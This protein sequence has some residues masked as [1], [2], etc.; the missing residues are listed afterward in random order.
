MKK[1]PFNF[2]IIEMMA[3]FDGVELPVTHGSLLAQ[4]VMPLTNKRTDEYGGS[5]DNRLRVVFGISDAIRKEVSSDMDGQGRRRRAHQR[6]WTGSSDHSSASSKVHSTK[7]ISASLSLPA[8]KCA[9]PVSI[10]SM[11]VSQQKELWT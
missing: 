7:M 6:S 11:E 9:K 8:P 2:L 1:M 4:F 10:L 5:L 3:S